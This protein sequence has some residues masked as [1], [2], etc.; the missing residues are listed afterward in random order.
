MNHTLFQRLEKKIFELRP[1]LKIIRDS[2]GHM[3]YFDYVKQK[4]RAS[5]HKTAKERKEELTNTVKQETTR[6][7]GTGIAESV[8]RQLKKNDSIS[9]TEHTAS[10]GATNILHAALHSSVPL[11]GNNDPRMK[12]II[13]LSCSGISFNNTVSFSRGMQFHGFT[14]H[15]IHDNQLTFFSRSADSQT[16]LYAPAYTHDTVAD[17]HKRLL[18]LGQEGKVKQEQAMI[19]DK[20]LGKRLSSPHALSMTEYVDQLTITN[21]YLW[22]QFFP[23]WKE[24]DIP[25]YIQLSQEKIVL[26]LIVDYHISQDTLIHQ[27]LFNP[28]Y[29]VLIEKYFEGI[30]GA[31]KVDRSYGTFLFWGL[32]KDDTRFQLFREGNLLVNQDRSYSVEL[33]PDTIREAILNKEIF[34]SLLLTF[35][36]LCFYYGLLAGGGPN[37]PDYLT[38]MKD[39][40]VGLLKEVN[41][42]EEAENVAAVVTDD[43]VF[44]R[45]HLALIDAYGER[46][47]ASGLDMDLYQDPTAW[48]KIIE[49]TKSISMGEFMNIILLTYYKLYCPA[50]ERDEELMQETVHSM[51]EYLGI[52]KKLPPI[53]IIT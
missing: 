45:S 36:I 49:A 6:L 12:N 40:Y 27:L 22:K 3:P 50:Q 51:L 21:Y 52:D 11:F 2:Y 15:Q 9:T 17:M 35:T 20:L 43:F 29:Y 41:N 34:P 16:V 42:L 4:N 32:T 30:F 7:L 23:S 31:F 39:A 46:I 28:T 13:V 5:Q 37:Q 24:D 10:I 53:G 25:H 1:Q 8:E 48:A 26:K 38:Q 47:P 19:L 33:S 14:D 18:A 44:N